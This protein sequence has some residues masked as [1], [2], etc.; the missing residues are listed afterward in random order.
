MQSAAFQALSFP[1]RRG[2]VEAA[3]KVLIAQRLKC[4]GMRW[5]ETGT[6]QAI[7]SFR[8]LW[9]SQRFDAM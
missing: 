2:V 9:K 5:S 8:A 7:L 4:S 6:G 1:V 3:N